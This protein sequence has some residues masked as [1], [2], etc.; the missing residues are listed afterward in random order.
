MTKVLTITTILPIPEISRKKDE[1]DIIFVTED[2][3]YEVDRSISFEYV[4]TFPFANRG[5]AFISEKW[6]SYYN[7]GKKFHY[8]LHKRSV[9]L[10]P[11]LMLPRKLGIRKWLYDLSFYFNKRRIEKIIVDV[12]P[13][14]IHAQNAD[15]SAYLARKISDE[16]GI[17]YIV[18]LR[19]V[20]D[21][22]LVVKNLLGASHL[23]AFSI[24]QKLITAELVSKD[25]SFIPHGVADKFFKTEKEED[26]RF[27]DGVIRFVSVC[28]L[29][30]LKNLDLVIRTLSSI[31]Y[32][33]VYD[34]YGDGPELGNLQLLVTELGLSN[35]V[36]FKGRVDNDAVA[37]LLNQ[38]TVFVMPSFP[39]SL[40]RVYFEAMAA[41]VPVISASGTGID[42]IIKDRKEGFLV[43]LEEEGSLLDIL[44]F[45]GSN[46]DY[47][48]Q[49]GVNARILA[50]SFDWRSI[51]NKLVEVYSK[52]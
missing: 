6:K 20:S 2:N 5:L 48:M 15:A 33:F 3:I 31:S 4:F 27:D 18:T 12:N 32:P 44:K 9:F 37:K 22:K 13:S 47:V 38:Y 42:G 17:P 28:R 36:H 45:V 21:D 7:L 16:Y 51:A 24:Q 19:E 43:N 40:G 26:Y 23:I 1:N 11:V 41:G 10:L 35:R 52:Y 46:R 8:V 14:V 25:I 50:Q 29:I 34:I 49:M 39:E 30:K